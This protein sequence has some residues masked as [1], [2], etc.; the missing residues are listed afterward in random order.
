MEMRYAWKSSNP[1]MSGVS[2]IENSR[3][4]V[5]PEREPPNKSRFLTIPP[6]SPS[7]VR[8]SSVNLKPV[9]NPNPF[10]TTKKQNGN[11]KKFNNQLSIYSKFVNR[12]G[13]DKFK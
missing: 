9:I 5:L 7:A 10:L 2:M 4:N 12:N 13:V 1:D 11:I 8:W 6:I 3:I